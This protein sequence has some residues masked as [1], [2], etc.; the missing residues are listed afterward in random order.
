MGP[1]VRPPRLNPSSG[2]HKHG[3][4][5]NKCTSSHEEEA[6]A[7]SPPAVPVSLC[8][9]ANSSAALDETWA[10]LMTFQVICRQHKQPQFHNY[11]VHPSPIIATLNSI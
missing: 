2:S 3:G 9:G 1:G 5:L 10:S 4:T 6:T 11:H 8:R 7:L